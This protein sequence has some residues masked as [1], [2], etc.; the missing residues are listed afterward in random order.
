MSQQTRRRSARSKSRSRPESGDGSPRDLWKGSLSFGLVEI[1]VALVTAERPAGLKLSFLDRRDFAPVGF[2]RYNK[3]TQEEVPWSEVVHGYQYRKGRYVG[4]S[5][6]ELEQANPGLT[7]TIAIEQFVD[8]SEIEPIYFE[9][10]YYLKPLKPRSKGY[11][12]LRE[13]LRRTGKV[14]IARAVVRTRE[15]V[16]AVGVRGNAIVVYMLRFASELR[17]PDEVKGVD[18]D[19]DDVHVTRREVAMAEQ[20][21]EGL[22]GTWDPRRHTDHYAADLKKLIHR[23]IQS[24]DVRAL[25]A[26]EPARV[27]R[28]RGEVVDLLPLLRRSLGEKGS[29]RGG[30]RNAAAARRAH[31]RR[32]PRRAR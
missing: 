30:S 32:A 7:R 31:A 23:K 26:P 25:A 16:A 12:L 18:Y 13:T 2:H 3:K 27:R 4:L 21:V 10:P 20:L 19:L 22:S 5:K 24:G 29:R 9:W 11:V 1:P 8:A 14:G 15:H 28:P 6:A 17:A